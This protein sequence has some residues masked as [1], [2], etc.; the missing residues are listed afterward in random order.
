[1]ARTM[2]RTNYYFPAQMMARLKEAKVQQGLP[3]SEMIRRAIDEYL[4]KLGL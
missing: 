4:A 2:T 3:L 1:M